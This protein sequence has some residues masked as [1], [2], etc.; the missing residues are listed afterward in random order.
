MR[1]P[2]LRAAHAEC[3]ARRLPSDM[4]GD[5]ARGA[6]NLTWLV[7]RATIALCA[8]QLGVGE[9]ALEM[10]AEYGRERSPVRAS[11]RELPGVSSARRGRLHQ[12]GGRSPDSCGKR[13]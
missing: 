1:S 12:H 10:T 3:R 11:D 4:V 8:L 7:D 6:E 9:R 2:G 5:P 13:R